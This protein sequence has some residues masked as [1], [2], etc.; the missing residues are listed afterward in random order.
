MSSLKL[1]IDTIEEWVIPNI[2][3]T[4]DSIKETRELGIALKRIIPR[5]FSYYYM[6]N[7]IIS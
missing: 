3:N 1:D 2:N 6:F 7:D 4:K 5:S